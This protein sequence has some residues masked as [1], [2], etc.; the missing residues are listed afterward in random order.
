MTKIEAIKGS[1]KKW[2][3]IVLGTGVDFGC[4]NCELCKKYDP[5]L[6]NDCLGCPIMEEAGNTGCFGTPY[7]E[8][9]EHFDREHH[10]PCDNPFPMKVECPECKRLAKEELAFLEMILKKN[11]KRT[12][13]KKP[14]T[15]KGETLCQ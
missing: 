5:E 4:D 7:I 9:Y 14:R 12:T 2:E 10:D 15:K 11:Q 13:D 8:W 6:S 3:A 1:I